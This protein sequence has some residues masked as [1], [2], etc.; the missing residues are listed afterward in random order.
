MSLCVI[1]LREQSELWFFTPRMTKMLGGLSPL[2]VKFG[3]AAAPRAPLL[4]TPVFVWSVGGNRSQLQSIS[5][6]YIYT[7]ASSPAS[8][9]V[10]ICL[11]WEPF[12]AKPLQTATSINFYKS[13]AFVVKPTKSSAKIST[14]TLTSFSMLLPIPALNL[15]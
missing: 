7:L 9:Q 8:Y 10:H 6:Y 15:I 5:L 3:G 14:S 12:V 1:L 13:T 4:P 2:V 11:I